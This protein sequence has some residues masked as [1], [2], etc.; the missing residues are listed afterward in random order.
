MGQPVISSHFL[1]TDSC[2]AMPPP[3]EI[4]N[5]E[6]SSLANSGRLIRPLNSVFTAGK[7]FI[8]YLAN[9][10]IVPAMSRGLGI[11]MFIAPVRMPSRP[12]VMK[13]KT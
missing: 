5:S 10:L 1:A 8:L 2:T 13:A 7:T 12:Q 11:R 3:L 9:S 4:T 6:K